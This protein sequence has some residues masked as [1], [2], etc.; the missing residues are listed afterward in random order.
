MPDGYNLYQDPAVRA[1]LE[2]AKAA[3]KAAQQAQRDK[4]KAL[5]RGVGKP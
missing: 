5:M 2:Q 3:K 1:E 4:M